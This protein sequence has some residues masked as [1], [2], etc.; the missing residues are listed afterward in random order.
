MYYF[1]E[2]NACVISAFEKK[3]ILKCAIII[4]TNGTQKI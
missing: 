2:L 3:R 4:A 1:S